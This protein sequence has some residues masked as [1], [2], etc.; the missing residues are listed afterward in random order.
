[1]LYTL[2]NENIKLL[3]ALM[4]QSLIVLHL[5]RMV[6][7]IYGMGIKIIGDIMR[8]FYFL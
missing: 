8:Q 4:G 6:Q 1:M 2:E 5:K 7:N 3:Q